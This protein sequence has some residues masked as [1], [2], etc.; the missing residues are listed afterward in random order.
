MESDPLRLA[1][2]G[3]LAPGRS[4]HHRLADLE[5]TWTE[6]TV[7]GRLREDWARHLGYPALELG[8]DGTVAVAVLTSP[9]LAGRWEDLDAYEGAEYRRVLTAVDTPGGTVP[10]WIYETLPPSGFDD[11]DPP[12]ARDP[13][14][15]LC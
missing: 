15:S 2:Y 3:T 1:V 12:P 10:A 5:G 4:A 13:A 11:G 6:G 9:G 8:G 14:D 7:R